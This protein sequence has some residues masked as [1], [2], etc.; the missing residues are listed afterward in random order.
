MING[1]LKSCS[2][3]PDNVIHLLYSANRWEKKNQLMQDIEDGYTIIADRYAY[4]G[5]V[6]TA[7]NDGVLIIIRSLH[8]FL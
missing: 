4:S 2:D 8:I 3:M 7:G 5:V 6:F 1:Y